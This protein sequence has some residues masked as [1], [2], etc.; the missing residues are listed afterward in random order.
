MLQV[1]D[2]TD[3]GSENLRDRMPRMIAVEHAD[4]DEVFSM[5]RDTYKDYMQSEQPQQQQQQNPFAAMM[6]GN[7]RNNRQQQQQQ[8][9]QLALAVDRRSNNLI[10]SASE[11]LFIQIEGLVKSIDKSAKDAERTVRVL[12][13]QNVDPSLLQTSLGTMLPNVQ[14]NA[15]QT[16][17][18]NRRNDSNNGAAPN[19]TPQPNQGGQ[20]PF[21]SPFGN[22]G[23]GGQNPF[24]GGGRGGQNPFGGG[25]R[26]GQNPFGGGGFGRGNT[27]FG[28]G[29]TGGRGFGG[30]A[31]GGGR[32]FGGGGGGNRGG[33]G[34][35]R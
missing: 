17:R 33:G 7:N 20:N 23:R 10:V 34:G 4:I 6:G 32:G 13:V 22:G 21:T 18:S 30:G 19:V 31:G 9:A 11:S 3:L 2:A 25:G 29:G 27:G 26:G 28:G 14:V 5:V 12:Q 16:G 15:V 35:R 24:G 1:L 8:K